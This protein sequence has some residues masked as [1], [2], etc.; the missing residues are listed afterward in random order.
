M[1]TPVKATQK[2]NTLPRKPLPGELIA[3]VKLID[4]Y[5]FEEDKWVGDD[6]MVA[7]TDVIIAARKRM[8]SF[9]E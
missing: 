4:L 6:T 7:D 8:K 3:Y 2:L 1:S 5:E 9:T